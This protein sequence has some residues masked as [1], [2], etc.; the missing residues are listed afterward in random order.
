MFIFK[1]QKCTTMVTKI[2]TLIMVMLDD[3]EDVGKTAFET[4]QVNKSLL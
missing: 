2:T 4:E 1:P 3:Q